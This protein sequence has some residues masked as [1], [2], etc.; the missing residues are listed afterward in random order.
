MPDTDP[1]E[2]TEREKFILSYYRSAELSGSRRVALYDIAIGLMSIACIVTFLA[3][4][5]TGFGFVGYAL[6]I[7][8]LFYLVVEG[9][10]WNRDFRSIFTKYDAKLRAMA[11]AQRRPKGA[12]NDDG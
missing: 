9:G 7:G 4:D 6:V 8:R 12:A 10:R 5:E 3:K 11:E 1:N 2:F